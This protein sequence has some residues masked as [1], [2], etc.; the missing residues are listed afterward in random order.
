[1]GDKYA[2]ES[3]LTHLAD[4]WDALPFELLLCGHCILVASWFLKL[5]DRFLFSYWVCIPPNS[6]W[7]AEVYI[8]AAHL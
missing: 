5:R 6:P 3:A 7:T 1:M 2:R 8:P 4:L